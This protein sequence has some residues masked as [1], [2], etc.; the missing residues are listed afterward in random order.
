MT[1]GLYGRFAAT[2]ILCSA[3]SVPAFAQEKTVDISARFDFGLRH[4]VEDGLFDG[5]SSSGSYF[6]LGAHLDGSGQVGPGNVVFQFSALADGT[7]GRSYF[8]V[9][10]AY[11]TQVFGNA[12]FLIGWNV[13]NW[14][15]AESRSVMN[16]LNP[17]VTTDVE[18][19]YDL[20]G[21][22]MIN[23][24]YNT[25]F[26]TISGYA[27]LGLKQP[28]LP[29]ES[30]RHRALFETDGDRAIYQGNEGDVDVAL[31]FTN[32]YAVAGG[33]LDVAAHYFN[34]TNRNPVSLPGC[35][36][37]VG[38]ITEAVCSTY[39]QTIASIYE[40]GFPA[41][42]DPQDLFDFLDANVNDQ[43]LSLLSGVPAVGLIPYYQK[44]EQVGA[45][46]VFARN[47]LQLRFEGTYTMPRNEDG[48]FSGVVGGDYQFHNVGLQGS[49]LTLALEY[50]YDDRDS[51]Q[52]LTLF[53]DDIFVGA[54]YLFN[55][56]RDTR[57][58]LGG[59]HDLDT[60]AR[61]YQLQISTRLTD[62]LS[63]EFNAVH[64]DSD[65]WKDPLSFAKD[66]NFFE[67]KFSTYF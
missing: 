54:H 62:S 33:G 38:P 21:T 11:Y 14:G 60:Q 7:N 28:I 51:R 57:I 1:Y 24:N 36:N 32:N 41:G 63:A 34:G 43:F 39:N 5:Q 61:L 49:A 2:S 18:G 31:R 23:A 20:V 8:N 40:S 3:L 59:F 45:S 19:D 46:F 53:E 17:R 44:I 67:I 47:D 56:P 9:K 42:R 10:K 22:P 6:F 55:D 16:V 30:S 13:E 50:L 26:G 29:D 64:I 58:R 48:Y 52:P 27:L 25:R 65:G 37:S 66:D 35:V 12:D 4:Y 15:V